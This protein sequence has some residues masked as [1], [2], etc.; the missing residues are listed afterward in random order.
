MKHPM[1]GKE[2]NLNELAEEIRYLGNALG[3]VIACVEGQE[4]LETVEA[5]RKAARSSR[6]GDRAGGE[7]L[8]ELSKNIDTGEAYEMAMA[9]T[10]YF[11]LVNIAEENHR[12]EILRK[13]RSHQL[14]T[15]K[16]QRESIEAAL[17]SLKE[18]GASPE[19][20]QKYMDQLR[21]EL[22]I[23]AH[24]T[25]AKRRTVL[26]KLVR[27]GEMLRERRH[28][29]AISPHT[30][31]DQ[32]VFR[33]ILSLWLTERNRTESPEVL[34]E[35]R[36]GLWYVDTTLWDT[37]PRLHEDLEAALVLHYPDVK[38]PS[39]WLRFGSWI[40]GDRDGNPFVTPQVT[41]EAL[42]MHRRL[43][44][45]KLSET[46]HRISRLLSVSTR[47][48]RVSHEL[49]EV[50]V[51]N[52]Y[53]SSQLE[54]LESRYPNEPYR[55]LMAA[56]HL[57][58]QEG[59]AI[60]D[61]PSDELA[62]NALQVEALT[63]VLRVVQK[64]LED[65]KAAPLAE[66]ELRD[67]KVQIESYG[68]HAASLDLR[69]HS[70]RHELAVKE[71][72]AQR[73]WE[74]D[75][76]ALDEEGR[77][78]VL[79]SALAKTDGHTLELPLPWSEDTRQVI[80]PLMVMHQ[81][82]ERWGI[83]SV[84]IYIISMAENVSDVIE[85]LWMMGMCGVSRDIAPLFETLADLDNA[86]VVLDKLFAHPGYRKHLE[87]RDHHQTVMLGYSDSNKDC[88]YLTSNW[89]L[90]KAQEAIAECCRRHGVR[91]TLF[92]G[93]GGTIARGGGPAAKAVL[94]Q[95][96]GL[97]DGG[98]RVTEQGE[99]LSTRYHVPDLAHRIL[100]QMTYGV[101]QGIH[102]AQEEHPVKPEWREVMD[103]MSQASFSAYKAVVHDDPDFLEFWRAATPIEEIGSLRLGSRPAYRKKTTS[104]SDLRA[105]PW[106]F[107]WMQS[108]VV[109]PGWFG[110]GA[111]LEAS[112]KAG[113][114][115]TLRSMYKDWIFF[116]TLIDNAQLTL[117]KADMQIAGVYAT[118]VKDEELRKR[119]HDI[120]TREYFATVG[121]ILEVTEQSLLLE[122]E[123]VLMRSVQLRNPYVDPLN[124][125]QV[126]M[127]RRLRTQSGITPTDEEA[128]RSV[129]ELTISGVSSGLKNT[130]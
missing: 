32:Q 120:I 9:F 97:R 81:A 103:G 8:E 123:P 114:L 17:R 112:L 19:A 48:D 40:G 71:I 124:Y 83:E 113:H 18:S 74:S 64:S 125:L 126:E 98:I 14:K 21:V 107:S 24:P 85:V 49:R 119:V 28:Q 77:V 84:G 127:L 129:V 5:Y 1:Q 39:G 130:G 10:V 111:G 12:I 94:A 69:Q 45:N 82:S 110:L 51:K 91:L 27:L 108:R 109:F 68:L 115:E 55:L 26:N 92:H 117:L 15:G 16:G 87:S 89:A 70:E 99:V 7:Q 54:R 128:I 29:E 58:M 104:V 86:P 38:A 50:L 78:A 47:R 30:N 88:G 35:V 11:E 31:Y 105:I 42:K 23:T 100:E 96:C 20:V 67:L 34:D 61:I 44:M 121:A 2:P 52:R 122:K 116:Q 13:R 76:S 66:G 33:E 60:L 43:A 72:L 62:D 80:E 56:L 73:A 106:V 118:L 3:Q 79:D 53:L 59:L 65:N 75:Y 22:V 95:P 6:L 37:L 102:A 41:R 93:R 63:E 90:F 57:R 36:T 46:T 101:I 25:E 4:T